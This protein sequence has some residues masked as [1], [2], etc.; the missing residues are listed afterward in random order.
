MWPVRSL[1]PT[2]DPRL[3]MYIV[4]LLFLL[5]LLTRVIIRAKRVSKCY[6]PPPKYV[7]V[8]V[9]LI[10]VLVGSL[11]RYCCI[12]LRQYDTRCVRTTLYILCTPRAV[13]YRKVA[14]ML[15]A[16]SCCCSVGRETI[17]LSSQSSRVRYSAPLFFS[18]FF[19]FLFSPWEVVSS[20]CMFL[21]FFQHTTHL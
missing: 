12:T 20:V 9:R 13:G 17:R 18:P 15:F 6:I 3:Q 1:E 4:P 8:Y 21:F 14:W 19:S 11:E 2:F 5:F 16:N 10:L 7:R